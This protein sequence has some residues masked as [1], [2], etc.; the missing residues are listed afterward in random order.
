M[1]AMAPGPGG[2]ENRP[3][4][5]MPPRGVAPKAPGYGD[6]KAGDMKSASSPNT[7]PTPAPAPAPA[8]A[9]PTPAPA[10]ATPPPLLPPARPVPP[11]PA[12]LGLGPRSDRAATGPTDGSCM[13]GASARE[14]CPTNRPA[15]G[16]SA[17]LVGPTRPGVCRGKPAT[18][19]GGGG[20]ES[21]Q[22]TVHVGV[23]EGGESVSKCEREGGKREEGRESE[24]EGGGRREREPCT[25]VATTPSTTQLRSSHTHTI[26]FFFGC[27]MHTHRGL[28]SDW[29]HT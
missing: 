21:S 11:T 15:P 27:H 10:T 24:R 16:K 26:H 20:E 1:L 19:G 23:V 17:A 13:A 5:T 7:S 4:G 8:P 28:P 9:P 14:G 3:P 2:G 18:V 6:T 29:G 22:M 25:G 12:S